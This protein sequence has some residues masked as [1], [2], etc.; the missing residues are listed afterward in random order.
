MNLLGTGAREKNLAILLRTRPKARISNILLRTR[1]KPQLQREKS[2]G[3]KPRMDKAQPRLA[4]RLLRGASRGPARC[5][6]LAASG[7][8]WVGRP[9]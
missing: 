8:L 5:P 9:C 2:A 4:Q 6:A 3:A 1:S 7:A